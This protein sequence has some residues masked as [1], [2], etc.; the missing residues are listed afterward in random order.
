MDDEALVERFLT[1]REPADFQKLVERYKTR[2][3]QLA[4]SVLGPGGEA[5]AEEVT[6]E[7]FLTLFRKLDQF[8]G[9]SRLGSWIYRVTRNESVDRRS[10]VRHRLPHLPM[11]AL[12]D[13]PETATVADPFASTAA[14]QRDQWVAAALE[15]L[16]DLYRTVLRLKYWMGL[17]VKEIAETLQAPEG[18][19]KS[20]LYRA[21]KRLQRHLEEPKP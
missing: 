15:E 17:D 5:E 20:Y 3:F 8:R 13:R 9:D 2:V 12:E 14:R 6:Q 10:R 21:R 11:E 7:V 18:T 1:T 16:P 4:V 19:V